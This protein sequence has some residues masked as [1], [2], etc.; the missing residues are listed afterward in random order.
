MVIKTSFIKSLRNP[1]FWFY[2]LAVL[3]GSFSFASMAFS[4]DS[5]A[6]Y[7]EGF[8]WSIGA[9]SYSSAQEGVDDK[10]SKPP[11]IWYTKTDTNWNF[12]C[13]TVN[14]VYQIFYE[15]RYSCSGSTTGVCV[16][17]PPICTEGEEKT[18][19]SKIPPLTFN[20]AGD[21]VVS[22]SQGIGGSS[23]SV[24]QGGCNYTKKNALDSKIV[25]YRPITEEKPSYYSSAVWVATGEETPEGVEN[26]QPVY[27]PTDE[28]QAGADAPVDVSD[29]DR[30]TET[31]KTVT[32]ETTTT[33]GTDTVKEQ[34]IVDT[35]TRDK[36]TVISQTDSKQ[37]I[38]VSEGIEKSIVTTVTT[39]EHADGTKTEIVEAVTTYTQKPNYTSI[40][41]PETGMTTYTQGWEGG[42]SSTTTTTT[43]KG[44]DGSVTGTNTTTTNQG[45]N[46]NSTTTGTGE[47]DGTS[48]TP[49][50]EYCAQNPTDVNCVDADFKTGETGAFSGAA[51]GLLAAKA[52]YQALFDSVSDQ[53]NDKIGL[54]VNSGGSVDSYEVDIRGV[55]GDIGLTKWLPHFDSFNLAALVM[56]GAALFSFSILMSGARNG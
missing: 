6:G 37:V 54:S 15:T 18:L 48:D 36:G 25:S 2:N 10:C 30:S 33:V 53:V 21:L 50:D 47:N 51:E 3:I 1:L 44:S 38:N 27:D 39:V 35:E 29:D 12:R 32:P 5:G 17:P 20:E 14:D 7:F 49:G 16:L 23:P 28:S 43:E 31:D 19:I 52:E 34:I 11:A 42:T 45:S 9:V 56:A 40:Y 41:D 8:Y 4:D 26:E 46:G 13:D 55:S 24:S 22:I